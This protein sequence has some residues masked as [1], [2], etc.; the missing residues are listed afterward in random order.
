MGKIIDLE[1]AIKK[2]DD[3]SILDDI[4]KID[5][6]AVIRYLSGRQSYNPKESEYEK[7]MAE[8]FLALHD[9]LDPRLDGIDFAGLMEEYLR[10]HPEAATAFDEILDE[11]FDEDDIFMD[12][13]DEE[14]ATIIPFT[15]RDSRK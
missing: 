11:E 7:N 9:Y 5:Y 13:P 8:R 2:Y 4:D 3:S 12:D 14:G 1:K 10:L 6:A 15:P